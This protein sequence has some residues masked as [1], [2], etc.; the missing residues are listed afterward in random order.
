MFKKLL[1]VGFGFVKGQ[2]GWFAAAGVALTLMTSAVVWHNNEVST[3][4]SE[5]RIEAVAECNSVQLEEDLAA[6]NLRIENMQKLNVALE[7]ELEIRSAENAERDEFI[8]D[9]EE[10]LDTFEDG[11]LSDRTREFV[12][13]LSERARQYHDEDN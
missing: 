12:S 11:R 5:A 6:A 13:I 10:R 4:A 2:W 7:D 8:S 3:A 1:E 9:L